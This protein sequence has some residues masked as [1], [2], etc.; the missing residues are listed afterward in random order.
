MERL[1]ALVDIQ[2][3]GKLYIPGEEIPATD[4]EMVE[5]WKRAGSVKVKDETDKGSSKENTGT[6]SDDDEPG[7]NEGENGNGKPSE[8]EPDSK[9]SAKEGRKKK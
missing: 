5:A 1:V 6:D 3:K 8:E 4:P 7:V 2:Y 9:E